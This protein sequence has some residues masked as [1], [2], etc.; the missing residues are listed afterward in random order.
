MADKLLAITDEPVI[1]DDTFMGKLVL[2]G[3]IEWV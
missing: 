2:R 1:Y 3:P